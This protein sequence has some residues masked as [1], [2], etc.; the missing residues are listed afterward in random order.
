M[1][2]HAILAALLLF[3]PSVA[4]AG[5]QYPEKP[6]HVIVGFPAGSSL[7]EAARLFAPKLADFL[8]MPE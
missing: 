8:G 6:I 5:P 1:K 4:F 7:D 2:R 3:A